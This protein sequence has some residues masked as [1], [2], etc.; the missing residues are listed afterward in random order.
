M[1]LKSNIMNFFHEF[2]NLKTKPMNKKFIILLT[3]TIAA[4]AFTNTAD[5]QTTSITNSKSATA[6]SVK[7]TQPSKEVKVSSNAPTATKTAATPERKQQAHQNQIAEYERKIEAN[8]N[9]PN[10]DIKAAE[11]ELE[12]LKQSAGVK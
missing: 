9:N 4:I 1:Y 12:R 2:I 3:A 11:S 6:T 5:A 7:T 10:F 8:R